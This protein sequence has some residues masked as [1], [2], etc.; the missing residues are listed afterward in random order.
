MYQWYPYTY[1]LVIV[2]YSRHFGAP[3]SGPTLYDISLFVCVSTSD[4][5]E[6]CK[7]I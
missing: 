5:V 3:G 4:R 7:A 1:V 2:F 6:N